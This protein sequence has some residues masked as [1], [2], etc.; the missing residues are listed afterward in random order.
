MTLQ[1]DPNHTGALNLLGMELAKTGKSDQA[2]SLLKKAIRLE[3]G[4][5]EAHNNLGVIHIM[6]DELAKAAEKFRDAIEANPAN[7]KAKENLERTLEM[8]Q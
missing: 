3:P 7:A 1:I 6:R 2:E 8:I 5:S 4:F